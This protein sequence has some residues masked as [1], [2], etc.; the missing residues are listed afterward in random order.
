MRRLCLFVLLLSLLCLPAV[1]QQ[2]TIVRIGV[3][4]LGGSSDKSAASE[5]RDQLVKALTQHKAGNK[6]DFV[7]QGVPLEATPGSHAIVEGRDKKCQFVLYVREEATERSNRLGK[8]EQGAPQEIEV[9][10]AMLEYQV[11]RVTDGA[12]YAI[13]IAKSMEAESRWEA[14]LDAISR[15]PNK[16]ETDLKNAD[17]EALNASAGPGQTSHALNAEKYVGAN[18]CAWLPTNLPHEAALRRVCE[19]SVN[20]PQRLPNFMCEQETARYQGSRSVPTDLI[21]GTIRYVDGEESHFGLR[22]NGVRVPNAM[23]NTTGLWSSGQFEGDL[24]SLFRASN[25]AE[26]EF[27]REDKVGKQATWVFTYRIRRQYEPLWELRAGEQLTAPP[28]EGELWIDQKNGH[29]LRFR[30]TAKELP[31]WFPIRQA[32]VLT[33]YDNVTFPDGTG[34]VLPVKS[35]VATRY[36]NSPQTRNVVEFRDCRKFRATARMLVEL[37]A[38]ASGAQRTT[39]E[40]AAE[41]ETEREE[42]E[43][44]Y[45][46]LREQA[47]LEDEPLIDAEVRQELSGATGEAFWKLAQ[48]RKE[49][50]RTYARTVHP[51]SNYELV[52]GPNGVTTFKMNVRL[53]PVTVVVRDSKG[54][55]VGDLTQEN[56]QIMDNR[57]PQEI[58]TFSMERNPG[59]QGAKETRSAESLNTSKASTSSAVKSYVAYLF[60]DLHSA[61]ED[62]A[63]VKAA[64]ERHLK[65]L[66]P[67]ER[68]AIFTTSGEFSLE[69]TNDR[70]KLQA[71]LKKLKSHSNR[72]SA[73]C[74]AMSYYTADLIVNQADTSALEMEMEHT[75][76]C[77]FSDAGVSSVPKGVGQVAEGMQA[78]VLE[79]ER[80]VVMAKAVE[81]VGMGKM[82][83]DRTLGVLNDV[84]SYTASM[85]GHR[86]VVLLSPGF[87]ALTGGQQRAAMYLIERCV[88]SGVVMNALDIRGLSGVSLLENRSRNDPTKAGILDSNDSLATGGVMADLAYG[89][90]GSYFHN[91]NDL[92][93]GLRKVADR[94]EYVY[95]LGFEPQ[96]LD[97]RFHKLRITVKGTTKLTVQTRQGYYALKP[98]PNQSGGSNK[99]QLSPRKAGFG[100]LPVF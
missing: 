5:A 2:K 3:A 33:E 75:S 12:P 15:I 80:Q 62:L 63:R 71:S 72:T 43:T 86:N 45:E 96:G 44:I 26:F 87:L 90:G 92:D 88:K 8:D 25:E 78:S 64:A 100:P 95:L 28:Y 83:S 82:E 17:S 93:E 20:E 69:F 94:P 27:S 36:R 56:F 19:Y 30:S 61:A 31:E 16:V 52:T 46:I 29:V 65:V 24:R 47:I 37:P 32:E 9:D 41:I 54:H 51:P 22:R 77:M 23:W 55:A 58:V 59:I 91:N 40:T 66:P 35:T 6:G 73:D 74:P 4:P 89:T 68:I 50:E 13:G 53:V 21:T 97:N 99:G 10:H 18:Y 34:F 79:R 57:K 81:V 85:P 98:A 42:N 84:L 49:L 70:D 38:G 60:D 76:G 48:L 39:A 11:R 1:S 14:V 7:M 67:D